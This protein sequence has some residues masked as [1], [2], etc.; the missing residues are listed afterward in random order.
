MSSLHEFFLEWRR[1]SNPWR[2]AY[3]EGGGTFERAFL[4]FFALFAVLNVLG[5]LLGKRYGPPLTSRP[6]VI[7]A[8]FHA[9]A[10]SALSLQVLMSHGGPDEDYAPWQNRALPLSLAYF[11]ANFFWYC[12]PRWDWPIAF[13]HL[14]MCV[15]HYPVGHDAGAVLAGAGDR[16]W[17]LWLSA[18][19]YTSEVAT[20]LTNYRWYLIQ[21][22][23]EDWVGFAV[24]NLLVALSWAG[25][26]V[27]F[28]H[29]LI[30]EIIPRAPLYVERKQ[31]LTYAIMV[32]GHAIIGVLLFFWILVMCR[33]GVGS[34]LTFKKREKGT[35]DASFSFGD[36][37]G[38]RKTTLSSSLSPSA[39]ARAWVDGTMFN[40]SDAAAHTK[41]Q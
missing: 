37:S 4:L 31:L 2:E 33:G 14:V 29:L 6:G 5:A 41:T 13:H 35:S 39:K 3:R 20:V 19:G 8:T 24:T 25:R 1:E 28:A 32:A 21:T 30:A 22:L 9:A 12:I 40:K 18:T 17:V 7:A 36:E 15:C 26:V 10:T 23:E 38:Q 16:S 34:L 27:L 11:V